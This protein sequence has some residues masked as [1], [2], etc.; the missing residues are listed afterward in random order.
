MGPKLELSK[1]RPERT[2]VGQPVNPQPGGESALVVECENAI[3]GTIIRFDGELLQTSYGNG[4][5]LSAILPVD[6][7]RSARGVP[8]VLVNDLGES[9]TLVFRVDQ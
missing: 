3:P 2:S 1:L 5:V 7:N 8:V 4:G 9:N 6:F